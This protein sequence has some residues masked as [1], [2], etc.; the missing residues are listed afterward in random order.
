MS[1]VIGVRSAMAIAA[2]ARYEVG[3]RTYQPFE[4]RA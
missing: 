3:E 4:A 2:R 1:N